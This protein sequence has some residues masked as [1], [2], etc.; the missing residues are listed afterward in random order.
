MGRIVLGPWASGSDWVGLWP[1]L[2]L[3]PF[4]RVY[5]SSLTPNNSTRGRNIL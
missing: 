1:S 4:A 3:L 2:L 5:G